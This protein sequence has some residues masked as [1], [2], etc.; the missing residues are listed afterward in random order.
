[1]EKIK[2]LINIEETRQ[3]LLITIRGGHFF[4]VIGGI[5]FAYFYPFSLTATLAHRGVLF[6][7]E[8]AEF[9]KRSLDM[10]R[11]PMKTG[12]VTISRAAST[13]IYLAQL[14][15]EIRSYICNKKVLFI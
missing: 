3:I 15:R 12:I 1:M 9:P 4:I 8:M 5:Y 7:D 10:L 14:S 13:M 6:L 11:Q 2:L